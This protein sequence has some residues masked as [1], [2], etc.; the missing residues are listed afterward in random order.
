MILFALGT[1]FGML[2]GAAAAAY[3]V[4]LGAKERD[5]P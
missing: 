5:Y 2:L 1:L 3:G 4:A